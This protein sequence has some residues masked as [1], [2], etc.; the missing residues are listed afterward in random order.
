[1]P[2][3]DPRNTRK[4]DALASA[5]LC[6]VLRHVDEANLL[7]ALFDALDWRE[8]GVSRQ[9][10]NDWWRDHR[11]ADAQRGDDGTAHK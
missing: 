2:C 5:V 11:D 6:G 4:D 10:F 1:M 8:I 3:Y 9:E 7:P